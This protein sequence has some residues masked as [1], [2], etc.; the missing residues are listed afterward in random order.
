MNV[1]VESRLSGEPEREVIGQI[2]VAGTRLRRGGTVTL[3]VSQGGVS[4]PNLIGK[5]LDAARE[6]LGELGLK[7]IPQGAVEDPE[8]IVVEQTPISDTSVANG[9][10][11]T[12]ILE[13]NQG[14]GQGEDEGNRGKQKGKDE[15]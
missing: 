12:F 9:T 6:A 10:A 3:I 4:V 7:A 15:N 8:A 1:N 2:P 11:V 5:V 14:E 13:G